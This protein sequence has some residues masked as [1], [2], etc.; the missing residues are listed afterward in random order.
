MAIK[1]FQ[2]EMKP[3]SVEPHFSNNVDPCFMFKHALFHAM[4]AIGKIAG[5]ADEH[6]H[7]G[8]NAHPVSSFDGAEKYLADLVVC[9]MKMASEAG[10][11][12][13]SAV[14]RRMKEKELL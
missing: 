4:K 6:D 1:R 10:I 3:W 14:E 12:L 5:M 2:S 8:A 7:G 11:D 9:A 13:E